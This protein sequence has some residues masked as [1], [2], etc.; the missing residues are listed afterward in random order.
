MD[1][2]ELAERHMIRID[3]SL[4]VRRWLT[5]AG[6]ILLAGGDVARGWNAFRETGM[7]DAI[8]GRHRAGAVFVGISVGAVQLGLKGWNGSAGGSSLIDVFSL[9]PYLIDVHAE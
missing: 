5:S 8:V 7:G 1:V 6:L 9:V 3:W 4:D 2:A